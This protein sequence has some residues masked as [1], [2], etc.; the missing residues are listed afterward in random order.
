LVRYLIAPVAAL[1]ALTLGASSLAGPALAA[2]AD[3]PI[4]TARQPD[5]SAIRPDPAVRQGVLP[6]GL[7]YAVMSNARPEGGISIRLGVNVGSFEESDAERGAAHFV[8]H[9]VFNGSKNFPEGAV[10]RIFQPMGVAFGRDQNAATG[11]FSTI[12]G[13]DLR[14]TAKAPVETAFKWVRDVADGALFQDK[15][16]ER[17][18]GVIM[19]ERE[20]D[21]SPMENTREAMRQFQGRG[22]RSTDRDPIGTVE[23]LRHLNGPMLREF[24]KRWYR[25]DN[26]MVVVIGDL[27]AD[28]LQKMVA[29]AFGSWAADGPMPPRAPHGKPDPRRGLDILVR[30]EPNAPTLV[31][32]CRQRAAEPHQHPNVDRLRTR[33]TSQLWRRIL[34]SRLTRSTIS[35]KPPFLSASVYFSDESEETAETC[36]SLVAADDDWKTALD[37]AVGELKRL[38]VQGPTDHE[39][40]TAVEEFRSGYRGAVGAAPT[41]DTVTLAQDLIEAGLEGDLT[42]APREALRAYDVAVE[43]LTPDDVRA[44]LNRDWSGVGPLF[45]VIGPKPPEASAVQTAWNGAQ[46]AAP[47]AP[48]VEPPVSKWAY[49]TFGRRGQVAKREVI[50]DGDFVRLTFT[51]GVVLNFK[52]TDFQSQEVLVD[53]RFANGQHDIPNKD[54][55]MAEMAASAFKAGGLGKES[56]E[57]AYAQLGANT[58]EADLNIDFDAFR[59]RGRSS[60]SSLDRQIKVL[61]AY[62]S[63]PGFRPAID[64]RLAAMMKATYRSYSTSPQ[65]VMTSALDKALDPVN[66]GLPSQDEAARMR[67]RDFERLLKPIVLNAPMEISI[68]GDTDERTAVSLVAATFG[69]LP[70][71]QAWHTDPKTHA[72]VAIP[73]NAPKLIRATHDGSAEQAIASVIWPLWTAEP[74][75]RR[76]EMAINLAGEI[77][78]QKLRRRIRED[79]GM[80]YAPEATTIMPDHA[81]QGVLTAVIEAYP[82]D[83][84][85]VVSETKRLAAA[86][87]AGDI[88]QAE[89][90]EVMTPMV[91]SMRADSQTNSFWEDVLSGSAADP[92][93]AP[94]IIHQAD[95]IASITLPEVKKAAA[96]WLAKEPVVVLAT[97]KAPIALTSAEPK[98]AP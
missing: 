46:S 38:A 85:Q 75:R 68:V 48:Y 56:V 9:M 53:V 30:R 57:E 11:L 83:I 90:D 40:E 80:S 82:S 44:A 28:T 52:H 27:P 14:T 51:N 19:A 8:E 36:L 92:A 71:R 39:F 17:E 60:A 5:F 58:W 10:D 59:L 94:D 32:A 42:P 23:S 87:V 91:S 72:F 81:D 6:N 41:R 62:M 97:P 96:T 13:L 2:P 47:L 29:D 12:Y 98:A 78:S 26:A 50:A 67:V 77:L 31:E 33:A 88:T 69:A 76:E 65:L 20:T 1:V 49:D 34:E 66:G 64:A 3:G 18:R 55:F 45:S 43:G 70:K 79:L 61:A 86:M 22:L 4:P 89:L 35:P 16:V 63:D 15:A 54:A 21:L 24:Y 93:R 7:R 74:S 25:P 95:L 84:D 37:S 73:P